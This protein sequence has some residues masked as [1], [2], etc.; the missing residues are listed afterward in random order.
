MKYKKKAVIITVH[1]VHIYTASV[2]ISDPD[3]VK[4][5]KKKW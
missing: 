5:I 2:K 3:F 4:S 1:T